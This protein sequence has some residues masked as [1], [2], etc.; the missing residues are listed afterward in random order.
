VQMQIIVKTQPGMQWSVA[1]ALRKT[2]LQLLRKEGI[3]LAVPRQRIESM[4]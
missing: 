2:A 4:S 1:R 3:R